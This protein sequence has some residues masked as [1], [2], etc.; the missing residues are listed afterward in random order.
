MYCKRDD[1]WTVV[2]A[3]IFNSDPTKPAYV[4]DVFGGF[5]VEIPPLE[6]RKVYVRLYQ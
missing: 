5:V 2:Q 3:E 4:H 1:R 6:K